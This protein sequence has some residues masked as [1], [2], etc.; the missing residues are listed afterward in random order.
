MNKDQKLF[1]FAEKIN[2]ETL[3][4]IETYDEKM[5]S[6]IKDDILQKIK[7]R[8][9]I[10]MPIKD[11]QFKEEQLSAAQQL[12]QGDFMKNFSIKDLISE[13]KR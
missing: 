1:E 6:N 11:I 8:L 2:N 10:L 4:L 12:T 9:D 5:P 3:K 13:L 7:I